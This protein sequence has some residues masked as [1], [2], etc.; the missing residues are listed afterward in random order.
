MEINDELSFFLLFNNHR[1]HNHHRHLRHNHHRPP[2][3]PPPPPPPPSPPPQPPPP[4]HG[5][6]P[7]LIHSIL[8]HPEV[9]SS[10]LL[11]RF[12]ELSSAQVKISIDIIERDIMIMSSKSRPPELSN[13]MPGSS[14]WAPS[15]G[16]KSLAISGILFS[17]L[18]WKFNQFF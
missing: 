11:R 6:H 4:P 12:P 18:A 1:R 15:R 13:A 14:T 10:I 8:L 7:Q 5:Q 3:V 2:L 9:A 17:C 16:P